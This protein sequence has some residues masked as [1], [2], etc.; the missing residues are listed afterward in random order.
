MLDK[1]A[2]GLTMEVGEKGRRRVSWYYNK[3]GPNCFKWAPWETST[4]IN[5]PTV[6]LGLNPMLTKPCLGF[7]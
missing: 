7:T 5:K 4:M 1:E 2:K 6:D 3:G